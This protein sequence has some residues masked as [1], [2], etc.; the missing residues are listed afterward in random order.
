[1]GYPQRAS[2]ETGRQCIGDAVANASAKLRQLEAK[3][4]GVY[5]EVEFTPKPLVLVV[6]KGDRP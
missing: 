4:D 6:D 3:A 2:A 1:M 5:K